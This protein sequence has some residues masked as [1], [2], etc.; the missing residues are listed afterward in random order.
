MSA[1]TEATTMAEEPRKRLNGVNIH[2]IM[3]VK[4]F[5]LAGRIKPVASEYPT[6][7]RV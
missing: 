5:Y 6:I 1:D 7:D 4:G 2:W 3:T